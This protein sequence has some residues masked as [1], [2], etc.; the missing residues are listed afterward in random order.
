MRTALFV[1]CL[2]DTL[3]PGTGRATVKLL[4]RLGIEVEFPAAQSCCGQMHYNTGYRAE[5]AKLARHF[6]EVFDAYDRIIVPSGSCGGMPSEA[7]E[8]SAEAIGDD[9][10]ARDVRAIAPRVWTT[11]A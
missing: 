1:T 4:R 10:L 5:T 7:Y 8:V 3:F 11:P 2:N 9:K 6:V